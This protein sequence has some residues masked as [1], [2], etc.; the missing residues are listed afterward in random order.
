MYEVAVFQ[1]ENLDATTADFLRKKESNMREIVGK[2]YTAL[3]KEL[4]EAQ[5]TL[6]KNGYG[7]FDKWCESIGLNR[8]QANRLIQRYSLVTN[9]YEQTQGLLEDL[10]VSLTYEIA[11]PSAESTPAKTQAKS[12]VLDGSIDTLKAY[13]E[14]IAE[15]ESQAKQATEKAEQAESAL[16]I[17]EEKAQRMISIFSELDGKAVSGRF[18]KFGIKA[19]YEIAQF[20]EQ[21]R[22]LEHEIPS[23][24]EVKK[25]DEMTVRELS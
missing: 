4:K 18:N 14:R 21:Q 6:A 7:C 10:P 13:R 15:L 24:G 25:V 3:G 8:M 2:A 5:D 19:L 16:Q 9:C 17:A 20:T 22:N 1:Y 11:K 23:T 12:E